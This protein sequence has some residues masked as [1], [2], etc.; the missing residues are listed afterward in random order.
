M[1]LVAAALAL[2]APAPLAAQPQAPVAALAQGEVLLEVSAVG[3]VTTRADR[4]TLSFSIRGRGETEVA[5]RANAEQ[6]IREITALL[7]AQGVAETDIRIEPLTPAMGDPDEQAIANAVAA[8]DA[9]AAEAQRAAGG[10]APAPGAQRL[11]LAEQPRFSAAAATEVVI[12]NVGS[13]PAVMSGLN[14]QHISLIQGAT[15]VLNDDSGP[16]RQ[17]RL[18]AI[19]KA[20]ANADAYAFA[21]NMR[22]VRV[23]RVTERLGMDVMALAASERSLGGALGFT[24]MRNN[25]AD[26]ATVAV[27][28]VDF[29]LAPR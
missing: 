1:R 18:Q 17:A 14:Q 25:G 24:A 15:Y 29:V 16:R 9:A 11:E 5:S 7:R 2:A 4:A 19:E 28:G 21:L 10:S 20:R 12:R 22:V 23:L 27:I 6:R 13:V 3:A 26:I 8:L